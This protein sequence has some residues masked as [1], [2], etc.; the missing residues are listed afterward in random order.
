MAELDANESLTPF[1]D[2]PGGS[3]HG[4]ILF[5]RARLG[6]AQPQWMTPGF[7]GDKAEPVASGGRG[8]AWFVNAPFGDA[9]LR[10]YRRG[11]L[12][13]KVNRDRYLWHGGEQTRS[14]LEYRLTERLLGMG[15]PVPA[16]LAAIYWRT[17]ALWYRAGLLLERLPG[18]RTFAELPQSGDPLPWEA[19]G[20]MIARFHR[21]GL[22]HADLNLHNI[23]HDRDGKTWLIDFDRSTI[24]VPDARWREANLHRLHRSF[25]KIRGAGD[26]AAADADYARLRDGYADGWERAL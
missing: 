12:V 22:D 5:D 16:P 20:K 24:R 11:G 21:N 17:G 10:H 7:W 15:L 26:S 3:A 13:A 9:V 25:L 6:Q 1:R 8:S 19:A 2:A 14:F 4:A 18:V 23:L